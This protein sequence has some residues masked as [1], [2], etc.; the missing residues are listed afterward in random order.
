MV[1]F[2]PVVDFF[3][4]ARPGVAPTTPALSLAP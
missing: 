1:M 2:K 3:A 4:R